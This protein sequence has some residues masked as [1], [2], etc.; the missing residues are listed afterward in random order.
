MLWN[1]L[2]RPCFF[3]LAPERAHYVAMGLMAGACKVPGFSAFLSA[4]YAKRYPQLE[5]DL[6]D[7][8]FPSPLGLA[9]G[10]D[11]DAR[12]FREL[13][14]L[15]FGFIEV[16]TLTA[17]PQPGNP[18]PR[19]FRLPVDKGLINRLG[20]NNQGSENAAERLKGAKPS[21][22]LGINIGKSK[23]TPL[24]DATSDYLTSYVRLYQ[25]STYVTV[26]VSSPNTPG[27]RQLQEREPLENL[28]KQL[29][30][31]REELSKEFGH[32]P[33]LLK[34]APDLTDEQLAEIAGLADSLKL[35][36]LIATNT[37]ISRDGL[38]SDKGYVDGI[39]AGGLSGAPLTER[40]RE[41]VRFLYRETGGRLPLVGVG[42]IMTGEDAWKMITSGASLV[43]VYTG[44]IYGGPGFAAGIN[45]YLAERVVRE[46]GKSITEFVG[47]DASAKNADTRNASAKK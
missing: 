31:K 21:I 6:W 20:F 24:E 46:G 43:Q 3:T 2:V 28:L 33:L 12:W 23:V 32:R 39:G 41:V 38:K 29:L 47:C 37:T 19:M 42:G 35:D 13:T 45:R 36:G 44:F 11:K 1:Y 22:P 7:R 25:F 26:N 9:A 15:G 34:I 5:V 27:L 18:K 16:G 30:A 40:S 17:L 4:L 8:K 10:F 14:A